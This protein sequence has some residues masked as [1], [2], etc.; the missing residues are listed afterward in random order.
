MQQ[1]RTIEV[2]DAT[3]E[4]ALYGSGTPVVLLA[5]AGCGVGYF[6]QPRCPFDDRDRFLDALGIGDCPEKRNARR[7]SDQYP[8][9]G[10]IRTL[11]TGAQ[12]TSNAAPGTPP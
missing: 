12:T 9:P 4:C 8:R 6:D 7:P 5:N 1:H 2:G 11:A 3:L 10:L